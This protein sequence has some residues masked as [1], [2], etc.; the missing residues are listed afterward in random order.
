MIA[1]RT[2]PPLALSRLRAGGQLLEV[3]GGD[4]RFD[5]AEVAH[6]LNGAW[7]WTFPKR[8]LPA[9]KPRLRAGLPPCN[10]GRYLWPSGPKG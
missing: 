7:G 10:W 1:T 5:L 4:L 3:R 6:F 8:P 9:W 2:D